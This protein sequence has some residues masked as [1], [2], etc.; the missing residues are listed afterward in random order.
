M[1]ELRIFCILVSVVKA[2]CREPQML[3]AKGVD[4]EFEIYS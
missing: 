4:K 3:T 1:E 2:E